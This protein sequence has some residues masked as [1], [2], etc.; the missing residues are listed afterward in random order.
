MVRL[1]RNRFLVRAARAFFLLLAAYGSLLTTTAA[2]KIA[3]LTPD[4]NGPSESFAERLETS[5]AAKFKI[6]NSSLS[7]AA[8]LSAD[9]ENPFNMT[10][11]ESKIIGAAVGCDFFLLV[12]SE[13]LRRNSFAKKE[14]FEAYAAV[15][16]VSART[17]RLV[18][19]KI[20]SVEAPESAAAEKRLAEAANALAGEIS[21][22]IS[23]TAKAEFGEK[24]V[25]LEEIPA[26]N[27]PAAKNFRPPLPYK[28]ISPSYTPLANLYSIKAT[29]E[30]EIDFDESGAIRRTAIIRWAGFGLDEAVTE[31]VLKMNWRPAMRDGKPLPVR[32]VLRYNFK[33]IEKDEEAAARPLF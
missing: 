2:Q 11:A 5:L 22:K 16:A 19:W 10:A 20:Q 4:K 12:K 9:A 18:F 23:L 31:T 3:V 26:E 30:I 24:P 21:E 13:N 29:V 14:Y 1:N 8:F 15:Y 28:R 27:S 25:P 33:K 7:E 32:A 17:G 6:L